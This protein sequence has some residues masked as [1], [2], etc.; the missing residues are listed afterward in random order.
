MTPESATGV[1][2]GENAGKLHGW[3]GGMDF[4]YW[5]PWKYAGVRFEQS[6]TSENYLLTL[7]NT[8]SPGTLI[9][10]PLVPPSP[11]TGLLTLGMVISSGSPPTYLEIDGGEA[12]FR[13]LTRC[14]ANMK[15]SLIE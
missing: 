14:P 8:G 13:L 15:R 7:A 11:V 6:A 9:G 1:G 12:T 3:G 5:F 10:V 2:S 4:T